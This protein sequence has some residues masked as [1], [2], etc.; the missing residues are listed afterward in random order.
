[1]HS[2]CKFLGEKAAFFARE[3]LCGVGNGYR[4]PTEAEWEYA[5]RGGAPQFRNSSN[6]DGPWCANKSPEEPIQNYPR[7]CRGHSLN[8]F[9]DCLKF[10]CMEAKR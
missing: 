4:L 2:F 9:I 1:L 6:T 3:R 7:L 10:F 5:A 8:F